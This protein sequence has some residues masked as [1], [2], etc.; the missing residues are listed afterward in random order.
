MTEW[1]TG[2]IKPHV[3]NPFDSILIIGMLKIFK[4]GCYFKGVHE[5]AAMQLFHFVTNSSASAVLNARLSAERTV[6]K[7]SRSTGAKT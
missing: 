7:R 2:Q 4:L 5:A 6:K 3:F 1:L